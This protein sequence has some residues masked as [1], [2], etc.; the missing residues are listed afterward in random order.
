MTQAISDSGAVNFGTGGHTIRRNH[1]IGIDQ[2]YWDVGVANKNKPFYLD[3]GSAHLDVM[4]N[5]VEDSTYFIQGNCQVDNT[6]TDNYAAADYPTP[7]VSYLACYFVSHPDLD[8]AVAAW[9]NATRNA[10]LNCQTSTVFEN[11]ANVDIYDDVVANA[12]L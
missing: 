5:V 12:G 11:N 3:I 7:M 6:V 10:A 2:K 4:E 9:S 8:A 1:L